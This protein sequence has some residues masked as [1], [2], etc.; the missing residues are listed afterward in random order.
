M[1]K[2][3]EYMIATPAR[4]RGI[5]RDQ[6]QPLDFVVS[7]YSAVYDGVVECLLSG[8]DIAPIKNRIKTLYEA[9]PK[10]T[11]QAQDFQLSVEA[12]ESF[13][14]FVDEVELSTFVVQRA[15]D[16]SP[17]MRIS[18]VDVSVRPELLLRSAG[19]GPPVGAVKVYVSKH[20]PFDDK[21]G[22]YAGVILH[23]YVSDL[24]STEKVVDP[25]SSFVIAV[26]QRR[27]YVAPRAFKKRR[28]DISA[29]C[30]EIAQRWTAI[31]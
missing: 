14:S 6:K 30:E 12:L 22:S 2:L 24:L 16:P 1:N 23:Q 20:F 10:T 21:S 8:N 9:T 13:L 11:W 31:K 7:R 5:I 27:I 29:A 18:G 26:F 28:A 17:T 25:R 4:R 19:P 15:G 3:A